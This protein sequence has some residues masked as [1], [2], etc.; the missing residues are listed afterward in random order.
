MKNTITKIKILVIRLNS[1]MKERSE[2]ISKLE[3]RTIEIQFEKQ[4]RNRLK[5]ASATCRTL[6]RGLMLMSL[7]SRRRRKYFK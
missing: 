2:R 3:G 6:T 4:K 1:R 5:R 7:D